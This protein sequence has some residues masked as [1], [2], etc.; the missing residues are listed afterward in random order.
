[1]ITRSDIDDHSHKCTLCCDRQRHGLVPACAKACPTASI[2]FGP[3][4]ELRER[5]RG[6]VAE[7][8]AKGSAGA[9]L[10]GDAPSETNSDL[11]SF[12]LPVDHPSTYGLPERPFNPWLDMPG[13]YALVPRRPGRAR[14]PRVDLVPPDPLKC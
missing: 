6:R 11:H 10:Y 4:D 7:L 3:I 13:D 2:Q 1:V 12:C 14:R 8:R 5:A 9:Y